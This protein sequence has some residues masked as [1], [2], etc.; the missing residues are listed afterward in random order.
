MSFVYR[1]Y[2]LG[3]SLYLFLIEPLFTSTAHLTPPP[4]Q[5]LPP[6]TEQK[7]SSPKLFAS[8]SEQ[9]APF[10]EFLPSLPELKAWLAE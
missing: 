2:Y 7:A 8:R 3:L 5:F 6:P 10:S 4:S 9:K 1:I